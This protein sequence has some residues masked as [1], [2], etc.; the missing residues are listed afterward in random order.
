MTA[1]CFLYVNCVTENM[2]N[3]SHENVILKTPL[4]KIIK[5][6]FLV[7][8]YKMSLMLPNKMRYLNV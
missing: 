7:V 4:W 2:E 5:C 3:L 6:I 8:Y 1:K